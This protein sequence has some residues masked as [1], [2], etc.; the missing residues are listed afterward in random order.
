MKKSKR[1]IALAVAAVLTLSFAGCGNNSEKKTGDAASPDAGAV[2]DGEKVL[3]VGVVSL[4]DEPINPA[5][6]TTTWSDLGAPIF[7]ALINQDGKGN[8]S[9]GLATEWE[10]SDDKLSFTLHL[11]EGVKFHDG[12][13]FNSEDVKFTLDYY[14][15]DESNQGDKSL[16]VQYVKDVEAADEYTVVLHFT[17]PVAEFEYLLSSNGT[18]TGLILPSDYFEKVGAEEFGR[19][20]IGTGPF[21]FESYTPGE[22][23]TYTR[24]D[25]YWGNKPNYDKLVVKQYSEEST[26]VAALQAG[27]IDFAPVSSNSVQSVDGV[28]GV[29]VEE[30]D[31]TSTLGLFISGA[32]L[33]T[34]EATQNAD[35]RKALSLAINRQEIV[36]TV[37][38]GNAI[39]AGVWGLFPFTYGYDGSHDAVAEYDPEKAKELLK[40]A[41]YPDSFKKPEIKFYL[42]SSTEY[43]DDVAQAIVGYWKEI[44]VETS[45]IQTDRVELAS[46]RKENPSS[47]D[48]AGAVYF[49]EPP[50]K[51]SS[52]DAFAPFFP[53]NSSIHLTNGNKVID[54]GVREII[55][56]QGAERES[57]VNEVLE[58]LDKETVAIPL[59][60]PGSYYAV[61]EKIEAV[62]YDASGHSS[63]WYAEIVLK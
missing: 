9:P 20:P 45:I 36:D 2:S 33:E 46:L 42:V 61:G 39:A 26:R 27:D 54:D 62:N 16:L 47:D 34:G 5:Q 21:V 37:F 1:F 28:G 30:A 15:S 8:Y 6:T 18:G 22:K 48:F 63:R 12:S 59:V 58:A 19:N 50:K 17:E 41:G 3:N 31:Y 14:A 52:Y 13:E 57:K 11:R 44:G 49:F 55:S 10:L 56:L 23:I 29:R 40:K 25:N 4:P 60:Y 32:Y 24:N 51:Y 53:T 35:V 38:E 7:D 43:S